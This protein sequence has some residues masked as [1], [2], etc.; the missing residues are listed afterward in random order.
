[1][2]YLNKSNI[3]HYRFALLFRQFMLI[4]NKHIFSSIEIREIGIQ[5]NRL[6]KNNCNY[7]T[8]HIIKILS[9]YGINNILKKHS[10]S[11]RS[12]LWFHTPLESSLKIKVNA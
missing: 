9:E 12:S 3:K 8:Q 4:N 6:L 2:V 5:L 11:I 10:K 7:S 1:M